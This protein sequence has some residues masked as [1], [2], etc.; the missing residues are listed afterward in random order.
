MRS[1][2]MQVDGMSCG[3]CV[4]SVKRALTTVEGVHVKE[5]RLGSAEVA[6]DPTLT[7]PDRI[8]Q[9]LSEAGYAVRSSAASSGK[10]Q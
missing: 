4:A 8:G 9:V 1:I 3:H 10:P 5:V 2:T 7:T 6:Y